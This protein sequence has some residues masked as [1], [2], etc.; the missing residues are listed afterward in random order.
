MYPTGGILHLCQFLKNA[1]FHLRKKH[2]LGCKYMTPYK[3]SNVLKNGD[4]SYRWCTNKSFKARITTDADSKT[5]VKNHHEHNHG[6]DPQKTESQQ[7]RIRVRKASGG[8]SESP[9]KIIRTELQ[10]IVKYGLWRKWKIFLAQIW[11][12]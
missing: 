9:S 12:V 6:V 11:I 5:I 4:K 2:F 8:I 3:L 7:L 10:S 1:I